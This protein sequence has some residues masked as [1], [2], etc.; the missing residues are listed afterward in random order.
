MAS[1]CYKQRQGTTKRPSLSQRTYIWTLR[2]W[3]L[4]LLQMDCAS[5]FHVKHSG[6]CG[7]NCLS[8][9]VL[10]LVWVLWFFFPL[11]KAG[12]TFQFKLLLHSKSPIYCKYKNLYL[13]S[14]STC[15]T[16]GQGILK[17]SSCSGEFKNCCSFPTLSQSLIGAAAFLK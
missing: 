17:H 5:D 4:A 16:T 12:F 15:A 8:T 10:W 9:W 2:L 6:Y 11:F 7:L 14:L 3:T 1:Q 13:S